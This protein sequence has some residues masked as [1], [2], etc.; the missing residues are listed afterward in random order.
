MSGASLPAPA[1]KSERPGRQGA[2]AA[3]L[4][5]EPSLWAARARDGLLIVLF[6][7]LTFV[8]G[9]FPLKDADIYWHLRTGYLIRQTGKI[10]DKAIFTFPR[11][12]T[13]WIDL[14]WI[15][16][17]SIS[18][19]YEKG[20]VFALNVAKCAVTCLAMLILLTARKRQ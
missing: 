16:Q 13:P 12:D 11:A 18:W 14:H 3:E 2:E 6:L 4:R 17:V 20:G 8:L 10:P 7:I 1:E 19:L 5:S 15:F 9:S